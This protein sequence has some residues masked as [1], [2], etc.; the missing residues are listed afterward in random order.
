MDIIE[1]SLKLNSWT[2]KYAGSVVRY[3]DRNTVV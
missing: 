2:I 1:Q 3:A